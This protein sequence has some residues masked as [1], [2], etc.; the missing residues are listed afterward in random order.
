MQDNANIITF[1]VQQF[2]DFTLDQLVDPESGLL[3][4]M[5]GLEVNAALWQAQELGWL[6]QNK[7]GMFKV[8]EVPVTWQFGETINDLQDEIV[9]CF[10][11]LGKSE[12]DIMETFFSQWTAAYKAHDILVAMKQLLNDGVIVQY[13]LTDDAP[14]VGKS[15]YTFFTSKE[16]DGKEW[17]RKQFKREVEYGDTRTTFDTTID[18]DDRPEEDKYLETA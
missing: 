15:V 7:N 3:S 1:L 8:L 13:M 14:K 11:Q 16:N 9:Y 18:E 10:K 17:G 4:Q 12:T 2:P 5:P 6:K